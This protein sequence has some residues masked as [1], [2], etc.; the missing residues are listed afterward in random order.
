M[1]C[2]NRL[3]A[4]ELLA[5]IKIPSKSTVSVERHLVL[6]TYL[7]SLLFLGPDAGRRIIFRVIRANALEAHSRAYVLICVTCVFAYLSWHHIAK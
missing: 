5:R 2:L 7:S 4:I 3:V 1:I 6:A